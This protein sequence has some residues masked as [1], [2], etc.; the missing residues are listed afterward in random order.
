MSISSKK[1]LIF[2]FEEPMAMCVC[3]GQSADVIFVYEDGEIEKASYNVFQESESYNR[4][5]E[6]FPILKDCYWNGPDIEDTDFNEVVIRTSPG[7]DLTRVPK[8]YRHFYI[9]GG[10]H[11]VIRDDKYEAYVT[12]C[13]DLADKNNRYMLDFD[14]WIKFLPAI[15]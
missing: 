6:T 14:N 13:G 1:V 12:A 11:L 7:E 2:K 15:F 3:L 10:S 4:L 8:G 5:K 9:G